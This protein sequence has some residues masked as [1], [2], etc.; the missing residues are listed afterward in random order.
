MK[1][2]HNR[3]GHGIHA[4]QIRPLVKI[5]PITSECEIV[6]LVAAAVLLGDNVLDMKRHIHGRLW[7]AAIL[8]TIAGTTSHRL[9]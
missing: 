4:R 7:Q 8:A 1:Q 5:A 2:H 3:L 6:A 9:P